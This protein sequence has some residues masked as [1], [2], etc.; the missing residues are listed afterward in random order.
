MEQEQG[1]AEEMIRVDR[2]RDGGDQNGERDEIGA[3]TSAR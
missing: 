3:H 1:N 2:W